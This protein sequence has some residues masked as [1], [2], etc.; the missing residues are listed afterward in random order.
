MTESN[1]PVDIERRIAKAQAARAPVDN[2]GRP[3][4]DSATFTYDERGQ[5]VETKLLPPHDVT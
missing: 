3:L 1:R 5:L 2:Q 4:A